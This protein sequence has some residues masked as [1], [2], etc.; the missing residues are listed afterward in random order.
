MII[1]IAGRRVDPSDA[2]EPRFPL[3]QVAAVRERVRAMLEKEGATAIA[4]S[5]ACGADLAALAEA[6][7]LKLRRRVVLPFAEAHFRESSVVDRPGN[8][9]PLYDQILSEVKAAGD[10]VILEEMPEEQAY[11]AANTSILDEASEL[12][13]ASGETPM[14]ALIW[15]GKSRGADDITEQFGNEARKR[16]WRVVEVKTLED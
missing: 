9:G 7:A 8:W 13:K 4:C 11:V 1:A 2:K 5:A 10:L 6:G 16:G 3:A 12:A 15:N 14:A